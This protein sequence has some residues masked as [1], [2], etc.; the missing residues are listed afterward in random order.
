MYLNVKMFLLLL[1]IV[2][3]LQNY[4]QVEI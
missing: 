3:L 4:V 2:I 1:I